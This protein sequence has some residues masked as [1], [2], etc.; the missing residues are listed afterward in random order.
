MDQE[1]IAGLLRR[2]EGGEQ[3]AKEQLVHEVYSELHGMA[4]QYLANERA[5]HTLQP[6]ALVNEVYIK[7]VQGVSEVKLEGKQ[8]LLRTAAKAMRQLL[9]DHARG[10]NS[11]KRGGGAQRESLD[12]IV[13]YYE[14]QGI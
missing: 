11:Q 2:I 13:D 8:H 6:T 12:H 7:I 10:R 3:A 9:I 5:G 1:S 14:E 4:C